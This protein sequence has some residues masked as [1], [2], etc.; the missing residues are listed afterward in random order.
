MAWGLATLLFVLAWPVALLASNVRWVANDLSFYQR[1]YANNGSY[2]ATGIPS[3][4]L[5][6][7]TAEMIT[8]FNADQDLPNIQVRVGGTTFPLFNER[9]SVHLRD[10]R[11]LIQLT[12]V[13]QGISLGYVLL[14]SA[15][16][17]L[18]RKGRGMA[19]LANAWMWG[20]GFSAA[21]LAAVGMSMALDFD[22]LFLQF[23]LIS[24]SND[25][26]VLDPATSYLIR[27]VPEGFFFDLAA[28]VAGLTLVESVVLAIVGAVV[29]ARMNNVNRPFRD[30][31][32]LRLP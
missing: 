24:F 16:V 18:K 5:D 10:V 29:M 21:V 3:S 27:M 30:S 26:W 7:A 23:H 28:W 19:S 9:D 20:G 15:G 2:Q 32:S 25:F 22:G 17:L 31:L 4:E 8:Y 11:Y 14:H 1:G 13:V 12:Y 6:R